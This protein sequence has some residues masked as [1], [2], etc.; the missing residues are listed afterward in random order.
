MQL[1]DSFERNGR[2]DGLR[3][4]VEPFDGVGLVAGKCPER[5]LAVCDLL[6]RPFADI[7]DVLVTGSMRTSPRAGMGTQWQT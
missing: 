2:N 7:R 5:T 4:R 6:N 1:A 3:L